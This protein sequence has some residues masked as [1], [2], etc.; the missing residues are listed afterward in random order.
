MQQRKA[1]GWLNLIKESFPALLYL[2]SCLG[3]RSEELVAWNTK[4][5]S[6]DYSIQSKEKP[7]L[8]D[9]F[10]LLVAFEP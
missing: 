1:K 6:F 8:L 7:F 10:P 3:V 2:S 4:G 9:A 5:G